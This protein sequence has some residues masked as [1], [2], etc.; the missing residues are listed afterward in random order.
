MKNKSNNKGSFKP[1]ALDKRTE[2]RL[3]MGTLAFIF[4]LNVYLLVQQQKTGDYCLPPSRGFLPYFSDAVQN[5]GLMLQGYKNGYWRT[6]LGYSIFLMMSSFFVS[7]G[8][9]A[10]NRLFSIKGAAPFFAQELSVLESAS[11]YYILGSLIASLLWFGLGL[12]GWLN[13][14]MGLTFGGLGLALLC[15]QIKKSQV[16]MTSLKSKLL[17]YWREVTLIEKVLTVFIMTFLV[18][19]STMSVRLQTYSDTLLTHLVL[20]NYYIKEGLVAAYPYHIHSYFPQNT[21]MLVMWCLLLGSEMA[22]ALTVWGFLIAWVLL[23]WGFIKRQTNNLIALAT[24]PAFLSA[25]V[26]L[27]FSTTIKSDFSTGTFIFAH[28][29]A[30]VEAINQKNSSPNASKRWALLAGV[31]CGGAV[32]HK[33]NAL[34]AFIFSSLLFAGL[35]LYAWKKESRK[36]FL[37]LPWLLGCALSVAPWFLRAFLVT[38]NPIYPYLNEFFGAAAVKPWHTA[39]EQGNSLSSLG[40]GGALLFIKQALG[41]SYVNGTIQPADWG[42]S[43]LLILLVVM[44]FCSEMNLGLRLVITTAGISLASILT[45]SLAMRYMIGFLVFLIVVPTAWTLKYSLREKSSIVFIALFVIMFSFCQTIFRTNIVDILQDCVYTILSGFNLGNFNTNDAGMDD[46]RW[47]TYIMNKRC[48]DGGKTIYLG[49]NYAY[50][51]NKPFLFSSDLDKDVL[52]VM[53]EQAGSAGQLQDKL[54]QLGIDNIVVSSSYK[55]YLGGRSERLRVSDP[56][57]NKINEVLGNAKLM[58]ASPDQK[59]LWYHLNSKNVID[60]IVLNKD[61]A[62]EYPFK[63]K[64]HMVEVF[65][66]NHYSEAQRLCEILIDAEVDMDIKMY[67]Q[68]WLAI[69][70]FSKNET[71]KARQSVLEVTRKYPYRSESYLNEALISYYTGHYD[72]IPGLLERAVKLG[73]KFLLENDPNLKQLLKLPSSSFR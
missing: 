16:S 23:A 69:A 10:F 24:L 36:T 31:L 51:L 40:V 73:G 41:M 15:W 53:G 21:E 35:D 34:F 28:Y 59:M 9:V 64:E 47:L 26:F 22:A 32:G 37:T 67:A 38:G 50:G 3:L 70:L 42:A 58:F 57:L 66:K 62:R 8:R 56:S 46:L 1:P 18:L 29:C 39:I 44:V 63:F 14:G 20:P 13:V 68:R 19:L 4:A 30:M 55:D 11:L 33:L 6:V 7:M 17:Q 71:D 2:L 5:I 12:I 60:P 52:G 72:E 61:D 27:W 49:V 25:P 54:A 45:Y 65:M 43:L 48:P